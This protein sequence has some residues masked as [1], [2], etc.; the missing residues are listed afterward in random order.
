[1]QTDTMKHFNLTRDF[2]RAGYFETEHL[3]KIIDNI[4]SAVKDGKLIAISG[5]VGSG[6]TTVLQQIQNTLKSEGDVIVSRSYS[7]EK[8]RLTLSTLVTALYLDLSN[9]KIGDINVKIPANHEKST[10]K[11][12]SLIQDRGKSTVLFVDEAHD[13][14]GQTLIG[15]KRLMES[16]NNISTKTNKIKLAVVLAG[17]PK[18]KNDLIRPILEE[19]GSRTEIFTLDGIVASKRDYIEWL[20]ETCTQKGTEIDSI[21]TVDALDLLAEKLVTPLQIEHYLTL[22]LEEAYLVGVKPVNTEIV[23][24]VIAKDIN[25]REPTLTRQGYNVKTLANV[26]NIKPAVVRS[27]LKGQLPPTQSQEIKTEML[28]AGIQI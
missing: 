2:K 18:L 8:N 7:I 16:I 13:L 23:E 10:R 6:K 15:L 19:I 3:R 24:A 4:I 26:L 27:F 25:D 28:A 22:A 5:I 1:M 20:I 14:H 17:H 9:K 11:L 21:L 12:I